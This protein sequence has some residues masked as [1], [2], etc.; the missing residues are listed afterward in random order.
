MTDDLSM[1][2]RSEAWLSATQGQSPHD[3]IRS[4]LVSALIRFRAENPRM[5]YNR[6]TDQYQ[7]VTA[8]GRVVASI[9]REDLT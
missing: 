2:Y 5:T 6:Q 3:Q 1:A 4:L 7:T 8:D 9:N